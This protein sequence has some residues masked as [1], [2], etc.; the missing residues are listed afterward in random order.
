MMR[1]GFSRRLSGLLLIVG[2]LLALPAP[3]A[4]ALI[5][6][7]NPPGH[8]VNPGLGFAWDNVGMLNG[9][10]GVY[11]GAFD[12]GYW[13]VTANHVGAGAITLGGQSYALVA[14]SAAPIGTTDLL[15]F[16]IA[17][18]PLL[19]NLNLLTPTP[20]SG[21]AVIMVGNGGGTKNWGTNVL[22]GDGDYELVAGGPVTHGLFTRYDMISG[23]AQ[24]T[25]GDSG[26]ALFY[27][28]VGNN[29]ILGGILSAVGTLESDGSTVTVAVDLATYAN[30]ITALTGAA[31]PEPA[32]SGV[33][34]GLGAGGL[35][36]MRRR[37]ATYQWR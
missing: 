31:I 5:I 1:R 32:M 3:T 12:T 21:T 16:R 22:I 8:E 30:Q 25:G 23:E 15:L 18:A 11:L 9:A 19:P 37:R 36:L 33:V 7:D 14:G 24:G 6:Y 10:S 17:T 13:V 27:Q 28:D 20:A 29:W 26:G 2:G 4:R 34:L 35:V